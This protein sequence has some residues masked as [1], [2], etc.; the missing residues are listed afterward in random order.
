MA[1]KK[2]SSPPAS[3][4]SKSV[5]Q[6]QN[7]AKSKA[8]SVA[9]IAAQNAILALRRDPSIVR[10]PDGKSIKVIHGDTPRPTKYDAKI[11]TAICMKFSTD[12]DM[13]LAKLNADPAMPTVWHFYTWLD[14]H[15]DLAKAYARAREVQADIQAERL[16]ELSRA[17]LIGTITVEKTGGKDGPTTEIRR[18]D[19]VDR[20]RLIVDTEKWILAHL[21]PKKYG[22]S[23]VEVDGGNNALQELLDS[24]RKR[25][26]EI[27]AD[28]A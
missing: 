14:E 18:H 19:N 2:R 8:N 11:A 6:R 12:P 10:N 22:T 27:E 28:E 23:P 9:Y 1:S 20:S 3:I 4:P 17:P 15:P 16:N 7:T 24:F 21:R 5:R 26:D 25:S 13:S